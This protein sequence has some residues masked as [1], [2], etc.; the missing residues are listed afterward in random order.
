MSYA[1]LALLQIPQAGDSIVF[2]DCSRKCSCH[3]SGLLVCKDASCQE[4]ETCTLQD[5]VRG[6]IREEGKCSLTPGAQLTSFDGASGKILQ[7]GVYELASLCDEADSSWFRVVAVIQKCKDE[8]L[9]A[10]STLHV[11]FKGTFVTVTKDKEAWVSA[12]GKQDTTVLWLSNASAPSPDFSAEFRHPELLVAM[13]K[14]HHI[15]ANA[16]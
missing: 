6:C 11:F 15:T 7:D 14:H 4:G 12:L 13:R 10:V 16:S 2:E 1:S 5:G 3:P 9:A 8:A